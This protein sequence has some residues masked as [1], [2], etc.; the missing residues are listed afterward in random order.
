MDMRKGGDNMREMTFLEVYDDLRDE[1]L[2]GY[3]A[4]EVALDIL[5]VGAFSEMSD[6]AQTLLVRKAMN[7][8]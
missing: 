1:G 6:Q 8:I 4:V 2:M 7:K 3:E 5:T